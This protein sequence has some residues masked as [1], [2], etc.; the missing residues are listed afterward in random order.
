[1]TWQELCGHLCYNAAFAGIFGF[2]AMR[3]DGDPEECFST[4][5]ND[6]VVIY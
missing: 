4:N 1:M 6:K 2:F 3:G 5:D